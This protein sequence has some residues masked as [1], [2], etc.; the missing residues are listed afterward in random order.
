IPSTKLFL[1]RSFTVPKFRCESLQCHD[2]DFVEVALERRQTGEEA[3]ISELEIVY[4]LDSRAPICKSSPS[5]LRTKKIIL[6]IDNYQ[7][8]DLSHCS[9]SIEH[10]QQ[11]LNT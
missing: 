11:F 8:N 7:Y 6:F 10:L 1:V 9:C 3:A 2:H 4:K 5:R